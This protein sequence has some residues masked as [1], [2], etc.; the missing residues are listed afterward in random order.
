MNEDESTDTLPTKQKYS[1][2]IENSYI[3]QANCR[4][5]ILSPAA[6]TVLIV[7]NRSRE[8]RRI[9]FYSKRTRQELQTSKFINAIFI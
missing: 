5:I 7:D 3:R 4:W 2:L 8:E 6:A 1:E 9:E